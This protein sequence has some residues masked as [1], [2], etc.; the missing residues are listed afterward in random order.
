VYLSSGIPL[1]RSQNIHFD[2]LRLDDV[3]F[4]SNEID[5]GMSSLI[6]EFYGFFI[7]VT[8]N[9]WRKYLNLHIF[10]L[11]VCFTGAPSPPSEQEIP[12]HV[13]IWHNSVYTCWT[14]FWHRPSYGTGTDFDPSY[15]T[16]TLLSPN[17][18][19]AVRVALRFRI[20][21]SVPE[22]VALFQN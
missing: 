2:G 12:K 1:L 11:H 10:L 9:Q 20:R 19:C 21:F 14:S 13:W 16:G 6:Q 8:C 18:H 4:I 17:Q 5:E 3:A 15:G 7:Q 22:R